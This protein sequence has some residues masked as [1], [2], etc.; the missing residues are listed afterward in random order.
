MT[1]REQLLRALARQPTERV[2]RLLIPDQACAGGLKL[3]PAQALGPE[4]T[5]ENIVAFFQAADMLPA[6]YR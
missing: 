2:P 6:P 3:A 1:S 4:T 5:W